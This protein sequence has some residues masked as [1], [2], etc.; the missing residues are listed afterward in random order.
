MKVKIKKLVKEED[1]IQDLEERLKNKSREGKCLICGSKIV[2]DFKDAS[3]DFICSECLADMKELTNDM[4]EEMPTYVLHNIEETRKIIF[5]KHFKH[6]FPEKYKK[7][8]E[9]FLRDY[10]KEVND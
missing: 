4:N 1:S 5:M 6:D 7:I 9:D 10:K 3:Y 2:K 8:R